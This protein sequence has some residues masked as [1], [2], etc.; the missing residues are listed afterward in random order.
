MSLAIFSTIS[1]ACKRNG[2]PK[3][4]LYTVKSKRGVNG[5]QIYHYRLSE[6]VS[7][8]IRSIENFEDQGDEGVNW[9]K[10]EVE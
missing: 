4:S 8:I 10:G 1:K 5:K 2:V 9:G 7:E 6:G 3:D